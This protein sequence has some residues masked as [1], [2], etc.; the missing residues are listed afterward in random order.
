MP[1]TVCISAHT[2]TRTHTHRGMHI[3]TQ[4]LNIQAHTHALRYA[5]LHTRHA[6]IGI[7]LIHTGVHICTEWDAY[8]N[9]QAWTKAH[10]H[11]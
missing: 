1:I 9:T 2:G 5:H 7:T 3:F 4:G 10:I 8:L 6:C 11:T